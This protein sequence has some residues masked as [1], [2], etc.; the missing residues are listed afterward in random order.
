M[1]IKKEACKQVTKLVLGALVIRF[2]VFLQI[3]FINFVCSKG[4]GYLSGLLSLQ[5]HEAFA[6]L[7]KVVTH[8]E[9]VSVGKKLDLWNY[10]RFVFF[11]CELMQRLIYALAGSE[12]MRTMFLFASFAVSPPKMLA[13]VDLPT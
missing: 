6:G 5:E 2:R 10:H 9:M 12:Q 7:R 11:L 3:C 4:R 8:Y 13:P 1:R